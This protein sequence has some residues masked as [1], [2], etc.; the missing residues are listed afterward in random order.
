MCGI[1]GWIR[2][3]NSD[4]RDHTHDMLHSMCESIVHRGPNSEGI[5]M[6][7]TVALGMR[8]LSI[9]DLHTGDQPVFNEDK[10]VIVMMNGELYN[11]REVRDELERLGHNF[12]TRSD[13]E[14]LPHL[15]EEYGDDLVDHINGMY[16]FSLWDTRRQKLLIARDRFGEKP[17][18]YGTFAGKLLWASEPKALLAHSSVKPA[19]DFDSLRQYLS[20]DYVPAPGS[21]YKGIKKLPAAHMMTV[22]NGNDGRSGERLA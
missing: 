13:T 20:Y 5:W 8:R 3:D 21:I 7:D 19:L 1:T 4:P 2:L 17:L 9:I 12:V 10:S 14:I 16:T 6:D 22:E 15:Y 18:Y 11:Y